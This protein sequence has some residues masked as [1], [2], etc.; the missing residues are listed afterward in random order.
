MTGEAILDK[1]VR[2]IFCMEGTFELRPGE[3]SSKKSKTLWSDEQV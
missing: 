2:K 1:R 3:D